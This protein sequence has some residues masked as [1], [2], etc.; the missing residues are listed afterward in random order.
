MSHSFHILVAYPVT[1]RRH[2]I[3]EF[4]AHVKKPTEKEV[5]QAVVNEYPIDKIMWVSVTW[6]IKRGRTIPVWL[7]KKWEDYFTHR[8]Y[9]REIREIL[10]KK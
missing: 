1:K 10:D 4:V 8:Y 2:T 6:I 5:L 3:K 7:E 9:N